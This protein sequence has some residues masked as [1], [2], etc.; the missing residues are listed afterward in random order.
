MDGRHKTRAMNQ[1]PTLAIGQDGRWW[2]RDCWPQADT[3]V[4]PLSERPLWC[5][6]AGLLTGSLLG[7]AV[8]LP[9]APLSAVLLC[10]GL[11]LLLPWPVPQLQRCCRL[12][13]VGLALTSLQLAWHMDALP[14]H[15]IVRL[16]PSL[17]RHVTVAGILERAVAARGDRQYVY[18]RLQHLENDHIEQPVT[19]LVRLNVHATSLPFLPGDVV[20]VSRLRLRQ[21]RGSH[22]PGGFDF[23]RF[24]R[25]Q[26]IYV[27]GGVS[28]P[29]RL[30]LQQ[31]PE[32]FRLDRAL[33]QWRQYLRAEVRALLS[34]PYDAVFLAMVL[35]QRGDL[36]SAVQQ[37]FRAS[38]TTHLL[39]VSGLN[40][41]CIAI[42]VFWVWRTLLR[43]VR[44][45]L[46]RSW[47]PGWRPTPIA[48]VLSMPP[49]LLYCS[50]VGWEVPASRAALMVGCALLALMVQR[51]RE[52]LHALVLAAALILVLEPAASR[53]IAF[54]L[55]FVAVASIFV[56]SDTALEYSGS[57]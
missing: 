35:G 23:E 55:S 18:L 1:E 31:R 30:S 10:A 24:M 45:W 56:V 8:D 11:C 50:L 39:V 16:L 6:A 29:E 47:Y 38:G 7:T 57:A 4:A 53:D 49:V 19:G 21:V 17:P 25:W 3:L 42:G 32:G 41:S 5:V 14:P 44:S 13:L 12:G 28:N 40:V 43:L 37:S 26:G 27:V 46:P 48:A 2:W 51:R 33:E 22:N 20:R 36:T 54:Q 34:A 15:H 9:L 52:P